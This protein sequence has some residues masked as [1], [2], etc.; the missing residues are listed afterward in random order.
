VR[1]HQRSSDS[2]SLRVRRELSADGPRPFLV[3]WHKSA[4]GAAG[5]RCQ[6][7]VAGFRTHISVSSAL[8]RNHTDALISILENNHGLTA[9]CHCWLVQQ[10]DPIPRKLSRIPI[11]TSDIERAGRACPGLD[12]GDAGPYHFWWR[13]R[14]SRGARHFHLYE[15]ALVSNHSNRPF[16]KRRPA[17]NPLM[18]L[19]SEDTSNRIEPVPEAGPFRNTPR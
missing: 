4:A 19:H 2:R 5:R 18:R 9:G 6:S 17:T 8:N 16:L 7:S 3:V 13:P 1:S 14:A 15:S 10:C 12:P 11:L